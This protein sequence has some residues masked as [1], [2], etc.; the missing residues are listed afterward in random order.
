MGRL[1][2]RV[3]VGASFQ[4]V[5]RPVGRLGL[6]SG[7]RVEGQLGSRVWVGASFQIVLRPV[8]R[9]G[10][11]SGPRVEGR[12]GSRVWVSASFQIFALTAGGNVLR[13]VKGSR[14]CPGR[15]TYPGV[16]CPGVTSTLDLSNGAI[17]SDLE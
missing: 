14:K 3:W 12:L 6:G 17:F 13:R 4:I 9:L 5:L 2:S 1:G 11:G 10:L 16:T 7:P 8:G 15:R